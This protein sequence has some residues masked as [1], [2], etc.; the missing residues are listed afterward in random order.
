[1]FLGDYCSKKFVR[2]TTMMAD[3]FT[4]SPHHKKASYGPDEAGVY[5]KKESRR[6]HLWMNVGYILISLC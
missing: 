3:I 4:N 6:I 2:Q 5:G 1:M